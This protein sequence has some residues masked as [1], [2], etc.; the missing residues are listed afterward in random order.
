MHTNQLS[1]VF[2]PDVDLSDIASQLLK[3]SALPLLLFGL[4]GPHDIVEGSLQLRIDNLI[5]RHHVH[6]FKVQKLLSTVELKQ[7]ISLTCSPPRLTYFGRAAPEC[8]LSLSL[9]P[10]GL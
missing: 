8:P 7:A 5:L 3:C 6:C 1:P 4:S 9:S 10:T 2:L